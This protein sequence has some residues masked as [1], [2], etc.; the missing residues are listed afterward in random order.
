MFVKF[1]TWADGKLFFR[2]VIPSMIS[3]L[4]AGVYTLVDGLFVGWGAGYTGLAA[5]NVAFPLS[6][7][8]VACGEMIGTGGA[9]NIALARGRGSRRAADRFF[10]NS[11]ALVVPATLLTLLLIPVL[12][13]VLIVFGA[14][15]ELLPAAR[16]YGLITLGGGF[17]LMAAVA[18]VAAMRNDR[19]P[20]SAML[21]MVAGLAAN[22]VLDWLFVI[23]LA[24]GVAGSAW[25]TVLSQALCF[26]LAAGYYLGGYSNFRFRRENF[27]IRI[28][29]V[30]QIAAAGLPSFGV[31]LSAAA[32]IL[33][34]NR[35]ALFY[36]GVAAV[37][38]YSIISYIETVILMLQQGVGLGIQPVVGYL[39]GAEETGRRNR[40]MGM[41]VASAVAIGIAGLLLSAGGR[42]LIPELFNA[43]GEVAV[44][45]AQGLLVSALVYPFLGFQKVSEACFLSMDRA[46]KASLLV[47][48]DCC[49]V[50]PLALL[51]LPL[52]FG[53]DGIWAAMPA[54]AL[55]MSGVALALWT[56]G[57]RKA[58]EPEAVFRSEHRGFFP[59]FAGGR[60][61]ALVPVRMMC[62]ERAGRRYRWPKEEDIRP[63]G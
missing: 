14:A 23:V 33:L 62:Y 21:V 18:L 34:H 57:D 52:G 58:A 49:V 17:F 43:T 25:A 30:R 7:L 60:E 24:G 59:A 63:E 46:G 4:T 22:I 29:V 26:A 36:G 54:A 35:Q 53:L 19:A 3:M 5:I 41:G 1:S 15:P 6:L 12:D 61:L 2:Y 28:P 50:L 44:L 39:H 48:L 27:R 16:E 56:L 20:G 45:A 42:R 31:Q 8:I 11:L 55:V 37:A 38:A 32:V 10:G 9:V 51:V 40:M 47:Y 13:P